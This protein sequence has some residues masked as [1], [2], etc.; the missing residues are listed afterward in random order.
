MVRAAGVRTYNDF[1][2][3]E[4]NIFIEFLKHN[5]SKE[6]NVDGSTTPVVFST[7]VVP[8]GKELLVSRMMLYM[9]DSTAFS[10]ESFGGLSALTNGWEVRFNDY[11]IENAKDNKTLVCYMFD[12]TGNT[13]FGK[14]NQTMM[15]RWSFT[16]FTDGAEGISI[17]SGCTFSTVVNDDLTGLDYFNVMIQGIYVDV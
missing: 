15:G 13:L 10:S 3:D 2:V 4:N 5:G 16:K 6:Q 17:H 1:K 11:T 9:E 12:L 7:S 14:E 8:V